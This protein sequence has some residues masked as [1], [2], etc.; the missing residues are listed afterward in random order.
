MMIDV[1]YI[2]YLVKRRRLI[3]RSKG[4]VGGMARRH[5]R[6]F[7]VDAMQKKCACNSNSQRSQVKWQVKSNQNK[8]SWWWEWMD[9]NWK[10]EWAKLKC[11]KGWEDNQETTHDDQSLQRRELL[12]K[13][14]FFQRF[15]QNWY[16]ATDFL[17][18]HCAIIAK[19]SST[20]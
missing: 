7:N 19:K 17:R 5:G 1:R 9:G 10:F 18:V 4:E 6:K 13:F 20:T 16:S 15:N 12:W 2:Y 14:K 3:W 11:W 8:R